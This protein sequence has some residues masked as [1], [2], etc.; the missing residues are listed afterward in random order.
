MAESLTKTFNLEAIGSGTPLGYIE[1][2]ID[3]S[4]VESVINER[5]IDVMVKIINTIQK[6][7][8]EW[9]I[10]HN[11]NNPNRDYH[12]INLFVCRKDP[13][14]LEKLTSYHVAMCQ[15][16]RYYRYDKF[17]NSS[18]FEA[19][20][21]L[22]HTDTIIVS[23]GSNGVLATKI[24]LSFNFGAFGGQMQI[25]VPLCCLKTEFIKF[26]RKYRTDITISSSMYTVDDFENSLYSKQYLIKGWNKSVL[27]FSY[28]PYYRESDS[29]SGDKY[30]IVHEFNKKDVTMKGDNIKITV[31]M[32][33]IQSD[34]FAIE[35]DVI[36]Y[37]I[38]ILYSNA[39]LGL[40]E[41]EI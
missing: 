7:A 4:E 15:Y 3:I 20:K 29:D 23:T 31:G 40:D 39:L 1:I 10:K 32:T 19:F 37:N 17:I 18:E 12:N 26:F 8:F 30:R 9:I 21:F 38:K 25:N 6:K 2:E 27:E 34:W 16:D 13:L 33:L 11:P 5:K 36:H 41:F 24:P 35:S 22:E 14:S 28:K